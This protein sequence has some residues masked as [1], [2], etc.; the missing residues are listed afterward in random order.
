M[1]LV[2]PSC[3]VMQWKWVQ[4]CACLLWITDSC[5]EFKRPMG[6]LFP[7]GST[8]E[9]G[10]QCSGSRGNPLMRAQ[11]FPEPGFGQVWGLISTYK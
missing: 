10:L 1:D 9:L 6:M 5:W 11:D 3:S 7:E 8:L 4:S 2:S